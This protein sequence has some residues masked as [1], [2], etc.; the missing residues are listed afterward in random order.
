[1]KLVWMKK[2]KIVYKKT[3]VFDFIS[4]NVASFDGTLCYEQNN[5]YKYAT[6]ITCF[7]D[8]WASKNMRTNWCDEAT[9]SSTP[10]NNSIVFVVVFF[11]MA[12]A[13]RPRVLFFKWKALCVK[14]KYS[15]N[16]YKSLRISFVIDI[17]HWR[18]IAGQPQFSRNAIYESVNST[19]FQRPDQNL[20]HNHRCFFFSQSFFFY[21][22]LWLWNVLPLSYF[23]Y[24]I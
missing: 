7:C 11:S 3:I 8:T 24:K 9:R 22:I 6:P 23:L 17:F 10:L 14:S 15:T 5:E 20:T 2:Q 12:T 1:M 4:L 19:K 21:G 18:A 13:S 16:Y